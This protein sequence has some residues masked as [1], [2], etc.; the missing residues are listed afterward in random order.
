M[1]VLHM[2]Y[3]GPD[4]KCTAPIAINQKNMKTLIVIFSI[5]LTFNNAL[6]VKNG[7][8]LTVS[9]DKFLYGNERVSL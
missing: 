6:E 3:L 5:F 1:F 2:L 7:N 9:G 8:F 4:K